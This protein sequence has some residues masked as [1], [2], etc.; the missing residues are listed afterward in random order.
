MFERLAR[1]LAWFWSGLASV[2]SWVYRILG[3]PGRLLQDFLNGSWL[4]H[5]FHAMLVDVVVGAATAALLL[6]VLRVVFGV[7]G[8][9]DASTWVVGL[10]W[11]AAVGAIFSGLTDFKDTAP[12]NE[13]NIA[14][15]HGIT[16]IA[17]TSALAA[18]TL[19]R[20]GGGYDAAFWVLLVGYVILSAGA[21]IGGHVVFKYGYSVNRS[22]FARGKR[23]AEF[24]AVLPAAELAEAVPTRASLGATTLVLV[25]R[26]DAIWALKDAC[27]H[28]G[29][30][31]SGGRL[32]GDRIVCPLHASVFRLSDG[33]VRHGP[34]TSRQ[35]TY[36]ARVNG[37]QVEVRGPRE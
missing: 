33:A 31:L 35:V 27:S 28:A 24:T 12:G 17:G 10:A 13:Q 7:D 15:L 26:G 14:G 32:E 19:Q 18:S 22:A 2:V 29:A 21:F 30:S 1:P 9:E 8:L 5:S 16:N 6:D 36:E 34:A 3:R 20:L 4:G 37:D 23:A 11:L 25:R